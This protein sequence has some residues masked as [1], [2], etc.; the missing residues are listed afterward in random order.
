[1]NTTVLSGDTAQIKIEN[2]GSQLALIREQ[3]GYSREYVAGKL[4][5]RVRVI[6]LLEEDAYEQLPEPVFI[7]GYLRAY[8]KLLGVVP[9]PYLAS[10]NTMF[11][12]ERKTEKVALWQGKRES[13]VGERA[14]RWISGLIVVSAVIAV[15][16]WWQKNNDGQLFF[17]AKNTP[18]EVKKEEV[19]LENE[20]QVT[21]TNITKM[22]S[23]FRSNSETSLAEK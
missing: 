8:A 11:V 3:K 13:H 23:M 14:V 21:L 6:E 18:A 2:P 7:K 9:D 1:M 16:I 10:F 17:M 22:Q 15:S 20:P 12:V 5:L 4:H 19:K